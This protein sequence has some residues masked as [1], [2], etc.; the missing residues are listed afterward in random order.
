VVS[1][2]WS[3]PVG[4]LTVLTVVW[5]LLAAA[6]WVAKP[7]E[8]QIRDAMRMLPDLVRLLKNL[9]TDADTARSVRIRL[10]LL[11]AFVTS[12]IDII[13]DFIPIIGFVD[14]VIIIS[15]VLRSVVRRAGPEALTKH[16]PGSPEGLAAVCRLCGL[17]DRNDH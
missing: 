13:P 15:L 11:L 3:I 6:L 10:V 17:P 1:L 2:W 7:N 12:P 9:A 5:L 8:L 14:D 16:W 4:I